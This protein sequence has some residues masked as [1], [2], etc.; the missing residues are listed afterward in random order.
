MKPGDQRKWIGHELFPTKHMYF[1]DADRSPTGGI[2]L[3]IALDHFDM[4]GENGNIRIDM[5]L[6]LVNDMLGWAPVHW[7]DEL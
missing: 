3:V 5:S 2:A 6:V 7:L 4:L 1:V